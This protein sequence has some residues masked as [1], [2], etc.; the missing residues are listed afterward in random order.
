M[1]LMRIFVD[2]INDADRYESICDKIKN[3]IP[4]FS[5]KNEN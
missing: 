2:E 1:N 5:Y 3:M 4:K